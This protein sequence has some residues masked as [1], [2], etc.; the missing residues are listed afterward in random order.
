MRFCKHRCVI[1]SAFWLCLGLFPAI[2]FGQQVVQRGPLGLPS[3][4]LDE[5][6]QWTT[7]LLVASASD[8]NLYIPDVTSPDW[9]KLNYPDY[10]DRGVYTLSM[11]TFYKSPEACRANQIGWGLSDAEH[12]NACIEIGYRVRKALVDPRQKTVTLLMAA[13]IGQ[14]GQI[15]PQSIQHPKTSRT[16]EQLDPN[17]Q[18]ALQKASGIIEKQMKAYDLKLQSV[19]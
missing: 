3:Q 17:T 14:D 10:E 16:W 2:G 12:L 18:A 8:V 15:D 7:P 9:L 5:T 1:V 4:V 13:M 19:Q 11:F 6:Q